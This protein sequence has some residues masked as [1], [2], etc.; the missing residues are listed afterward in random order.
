[1]NL[2]YLTSIVIFLPL[3]GALLMLP[4]RRVSAIRWT[5]LATTTVTFLISLLLYVG[6]DPAGSP[7]Q[8]QF[9]D[10]IAGWFPGLDIQY[11]VGIDGLGLLLILLTTLLGPSSCSRRGTTSTGTRRLLH[12]AAGAADRHDGRLR[13]L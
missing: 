6:Y 9:V 1:M 13:R 2:P 5:A 8:P 11:Y 3:V 12:A 4:M 10:R 7:A